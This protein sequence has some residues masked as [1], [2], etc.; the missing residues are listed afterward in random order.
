MT[1]QLPCSSRRPPLPA[2]SQGPCPPAAPQAPSQVCCLGGAGWAPLHGLLLLRAL[3]GKR[4]RMITPAT[5]LHFSSVHLTS[6]THPPTQAGMMMAPFPM[7][8]SMMQASAAPS[9]CTALLYASWQLLPLRTCALL[10][11]QQSSRFGAALEHQPWCST[12]RSAP[13]LLCAKACTL[14]LVLFRSPPHPPNECS[15]CRTLSLW[16]PPREAPAAPEHP[17]APRRSE[18]R[19]PRH[20]QQRSPA[21]AS[22]SLRQLA[23]RGSAPPRG[24]APRGGAVL[25]ASLF[26]PSGPAALLFQP[27][28]S[29]AQRPAPIPVHAVFAARR[30]P[31]PH[32]HPLHFLGPLALAPPSATPLFHQ[33]PPLFQRITFSSSQPC[34]VFPSAPLHSQHCLPPSLTSPCSTVPCCSFMLQNKKKNS[35]QAVTGEGCTG[36]YA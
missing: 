9:H 18:P 27:S 25:V 11:G 26:R 7:A 23:S 34:L 33:A 13:W 1:R 35:A 21:C 32:P 36:S 3:F 5:L 30:P 8:Y 10:T 16:R 14:T 2:A 28:G 6:P 31:L 17:P 4:R 29:R 24:L 20:G 15:R 19:Q 22:A 12:S